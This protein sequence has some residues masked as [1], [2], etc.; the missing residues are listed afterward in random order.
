MLLLMHSYVE[1]AMF[2]RVI[3]TFEKSK[4]GGLKNG[5]IGY[6]SFTADQMRCSISMYI[7]YTFL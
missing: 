2:I 6:A 5:A 4:K 7:F 3:F 1:V